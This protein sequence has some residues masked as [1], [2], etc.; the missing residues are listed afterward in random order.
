MIVNEGS[1]K[2]AM[3]HGDEAIVTALNAGRDYDEAAHLGME[4]AVRAYTAL[5]Q[6]RG[7]RL[8]EPGMILM[9]LD[10]QEAGAM[11]LL[12]EAWLKNPD[13]ETSQNASQN[14]TL[15]DRP[16]NV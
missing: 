3:R 16:E 8:C 9:P 6:Q 14:A 5:E 11:N 15:A 12:S 10:A 2:V 1:L 7:V 4:T 13:N